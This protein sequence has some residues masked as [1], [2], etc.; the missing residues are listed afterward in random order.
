[1]H[2]IPDLGVANEPRPA[3][4][5]RLTIICACQRQRMREPAFRLSSNVCTEFGQ[6]AQSAS[7]IWTEPW[8]KAR[9][10]G[11]MVKSFIPG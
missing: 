4:S 10:I 7:E 8:W 5:P 1:M 11:L 3:I 9:A 2:S 6:M